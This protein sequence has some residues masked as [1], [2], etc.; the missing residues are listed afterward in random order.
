MMAKLTAKEIWGIKR[1]KEGFITGINSKADKYCGN[2]RPARKVMCQLKKGHKGS[3][4]A[5]IFWEDE[6]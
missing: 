5:V 3:H 6:K 1:W 2:K 4:R